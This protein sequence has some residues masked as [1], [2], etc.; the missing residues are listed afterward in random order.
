[1]L[2][3]LI[4][5]LFSYDGILRICALNWHISKHLSFDSK[6]PVAPGNV[7]WMWCWSI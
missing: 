1:M 6:I 7:Y 2:S 3:P 4:V 5:E